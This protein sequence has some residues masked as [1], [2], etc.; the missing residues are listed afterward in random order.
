M[1]NFLTKPQFKKTLDGYVDFQPDLI[2]EIT[3]A[4]DLSCS[5]CYAANILV[6]RDSHAST[7]QFIN[8]DALDLTMKDIGHVGL[9][10]IRGGEP[11][12]H[13]SI[14]EILEVAEKNTETTVLET[15]GRWIESNDSLLNV[16]RE[17]RIIIKI[18]FDSMHGLPATKLFEAHKVLEANSVN[19][20]VAITEFSYGDFLKTRALCPWVSDDQIIYQKKATHL[21]ELIKPRIGVITVD[22]IL[23][24]TLSVKNTFLGE[25]QHA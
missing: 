12:I 6:R 15:H 7:A 2:A 24:A 18:S 19:Y 10:T 13:P 16:C 3:N 17:N 25:E 23:N 1:L 14:G 9:L 21:D 22:G 4:C 20:L 5:G 8:P 11:S